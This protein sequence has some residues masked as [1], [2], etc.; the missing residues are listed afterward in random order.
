MQ[1]MQPFASWFFSFCRVRR[2]RCQCHPSALASRLA[3]SRQGFL[4]RASLAPERNNTAPGTRSMSTIRKFFVSVCRVLREGGVWAFRLLGSL[5]ALHL[6]YRTYRVTSGRQCNCSLF[7]L[8]CGSFAKGCSLFG[9]LDH[10]WMTLTHLH[11][12]DPQ[13]LED[14]QLRSA[15]Q[16]HA[17][18]VW[19]GRLLP[20][21]SFRR[22]HDFVRVFPGQHTS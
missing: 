22:S 19:S 20:I 17:P 4:R 3:T 21:L 6:D 18:T 7:L 9:R 10:Y 2:G 1:R 11:G 5:A 14:R 16:P 12:N 8:S 15:L 13:T